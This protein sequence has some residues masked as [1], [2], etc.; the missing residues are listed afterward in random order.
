[1]PEQKYQSKEEQNSDEFLER[2]QKERGDAKCHTEEYRECDHLSFAPSFS[3]KPV[4]KVIEISSEWGS[5]SK[6]SR[7]DNN[8]GI[9]ERKPEDKECGCYF[10]A[11]IDRKCSEH[12]PKEHRAGITHDDSIRRK[13]KQRAT[14][15]NTGED[16]CDER[17]LRLMNALTERQES[18]GACA[19]DGEDAHLPRNTIEPI[20]C[21]HGEQ[22]P[23]DREDATPEWERAK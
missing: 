16:E 19:D 11:R 23:H 12:E 14:Q 4:V 3:H 13:I 8:N 7:Y 9:D 21:V 22:E 5:T 18:N 20:E 6:Y 1:M 2:A 15:R 10:P 17:D